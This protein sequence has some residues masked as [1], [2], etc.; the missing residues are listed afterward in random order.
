MRLIIAVLLVAF[1]ALAED[2]VIFRDAGS[3]PREQLTRYLNSIA[4]KQ[5]D[6]RARA[7][8]AIRTRA[9]AEKRK[10]LVREKMLA[11]I[12]GLPEYR[13]PLNVRQFGAVD[14]GEYRIEKI[15]YDSLP[16]FHVTANV[17]VPSRG[18][19]PFPAILM[20]VGHGRDGKGG[21][22]QVAIGLALKGFIALAFDPIG[23][24]ERLQYYDAEL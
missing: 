18:A 16:N 22:Q 21:S 14:R 5:L 11:L 12:G 3:A 17:Y 24:G 1:A 19:K 9:D 2:F 7:V 4:F 8:A 6:A 20:P 23:Q 15:V 10:S 13:G